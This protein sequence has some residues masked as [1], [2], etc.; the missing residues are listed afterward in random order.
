MKIP[1][2]QFSAVPRAEQISTAAIAAGARAKMHGP[3]QALTKVATEFGNKLLQAEAEAEYQNLENGLRQEANDLWNNLQENTPIT[4]DGASTHE[5]LQKAYEDGFAKLSKDYQGKIKYHQ[6]KQAFG[7]TINDTKFMM[8]QTVN[9]AVR[10]RRLSHLEGTYIENLAGIDLNAPDAQAKADDIFE[11]AMANQVWTPARIQNEAISFRDRKADNDMT[12]DF[13]GARDPN[14]PTATLEWIS[15]YQFPEWMGEDEILRQQVSWTARANADQSK[16]D[17][18]R[19]NRKAGYKAAKSGMDDNLGSMADTASS[20]A[21]LSDNFISGAEQAIKDFNELQTKAAADGVVLDNSKVI[22]LQTAMKHHFEGQQI[23]VNSTYDEM[24]AQMQVLEATPI[25]SPEQ[26]ERRDALVKTLSNITKQL[27][28]DPEAAAVSMGL[29]NPRE[30]TL[31]EAI[32]TGDLGTYLKESV[33]RK[34]LINARFGI[35]APLFDE[36]EKAIISEHLDSPEGHKMLAN[37]VDT[38]AD[39]ADDFLYDVMGQGKP[40]L[41]VTGDL[42]RQADAQKATGALQKAKEMEQQGMLK[43][44]AMKEADA[45][46]AL[47]EQLGDFDL[48]NQDPVYLSALSKTVNRVYAVMAADAGITSDDVMDEDL[49]SKAFK[50]VI[51]PIVEVK[52][53]KVISARRNMGEVYMTQWIEGIGAKDLLDVDHDFENLDQLAEEINTGV[54][55]LVSTGDQG[56]YNLMRNGM[57]VLHKDSKKAGTNIPFELRYE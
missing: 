25:D 10:S 5:Q 37:V 35:N 19:N 39:G 33:G 47:K 50:S 36:G 24:V 34:G 6:N 53:S 45:F 27:E 54:V 55:K 49:Y 22:E 46:G 32:Q 43:Q 29:L 44:Y 18:E 41:A 2:F 21:I 1:Q 17:A 30:L 52:G 14:D 42:H 57:M 26:G 20:G 8:D 12:N 28:S 11:S 51:G 7:N 4:V 38:L 40:V 3:M 31:N 9:K 23:V 15:N 16:L 13:N 48:F 56:V